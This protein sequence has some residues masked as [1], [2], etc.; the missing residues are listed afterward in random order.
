MALSSDLTPVSSQETVL[1][2]AETPVEKLVEKPGMT[3]ASPA[4]NGIL[5]APYGAKKPLSPAQLINL[6]VGVVGI[7][8]AW[9]MQIALSSRVLEPLGADPFL[10][11]LI[12]CAG[13]ITGLL[14]QPIIGALSDNT[15]LQN[16]LLGGRRKPFILLGGF[17]GAL[18]LLAFPFA[19]SLLMAAALIWV[20][21]ACVNI[22]QG[23][24]RALVPDLAP[25]EQTTLANSYLNTGFG[26]GA[27]VSLSVAPILNLFGIE[28]SVAAQYVMAA[29]ALISLIGYTSLTIR[30]IKPEA[31]DPGQ[32]QAPKPS[33][34]SAFAVFAK[35]N[36]EIHKISAVQF[37]TWLALMCMFIYFTPFVVHS[38]YQ[39]PDAST[40]AYKQEQAFYQAI[41]PLMQKAKARQAQLPSSDLN[42]L[43]RQYA[44][45]MAQPITI[46]NLASQ[47]AW[48]NEQLNQTLGL[49]VANWQSL[50]DWSAQLTNQSTAPAQASATAAQVVQASTQ[51]MLTSQVEAKALVL[52]TLAGSSQPEALGNPLS[53]ATGGAA[54]Q[55]QEDIRLLQAA[56]ERQDRFKHLTSEATN[57]A[58]W[59]L[60][61]FNG[62]S[63]LL[64]IPLGMLGTRFGKKPVYS[65]T[66]FIMA[67]AF[68]LAPWLQTPA[69]VIGMMACAGVAWATILSIPFAFLCDYMPEGQE[70]S[71]MGIFNMFVAA[72]Q[73]ISATVIAW[74]I[75]Q[76]PVTLAYGTS[77]NYSLA[78]TAAA[79]SAF[80]AV[81][82]LQQVQEKRAELPATQT[83]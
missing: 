13:P 36:P 40:V 37:F 51:T 18:S 22:S 63:L 35:A 24:Y 14:V 26:I 76:S 3:P 67:L 34:W 59:A 11:G 53:P 52:Q 25:H 58:Q 42:A 32:K 82:L 65:A 6:S 17:L 81:V 27:V 33:L 70:G 68:A 31:V 10:L 28:M 54:S 83:A 45:Q 56:Y 47:N 23:P 64:A 49:T 8:F 30:E 46:K 79:V 77:Y 38:V 16:P 80:I 29:V 73:L 15:W 57:T 48:L 43:N 9:S 78:F 66:L 50:E 5:A 2:G 55:Q 44:N 75:N 19:P 71:L 41:D 60:V 4:G 39:L 1:G 62:L 7:Q 69:G 12:W 20:I 72:P 74:W 61:A 21:D